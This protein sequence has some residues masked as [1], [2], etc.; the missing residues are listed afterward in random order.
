MTVILYAILALCV[1]ALLG[2]SAFHSI[3]YLCRKLFVCFLNTQPTEDS[4]LDANG[5]LKASLSDEDIMPLSERRLASVMRIKVGETLMDIPAYA[6]K[7][8]GMGY[9]MTKELLEKTK[10]IVTQQVNYVE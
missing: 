9:P 10:F 2:Y 5:S 1:I 4:I 6:R 3:A 7:E 8:K